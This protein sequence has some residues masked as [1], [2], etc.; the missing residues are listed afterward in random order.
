MYKLNDFTFNVLFHDLVICSREMASREAERPTLEDYI[1]SK[2]EQV[3]LLRLEGGGSPLHP[4]ME[5]IYTDL[6]RRR[7]ESKLRE[8]SRQENFKVS[9]TLTPYE[10]VCL[11][12]E[13][14]VI[15][16]KLKIGKLAMATPTGRHID[17]LWHCKVSSGLVSA[18]AESERKEVAKEM[19]AQSFLRKLE[20]ASSPQLRLANF[21]KYELPK[22]FLI[23]P[24]VIT[25]VEQLANQLGKSLEL[26]QIAETAWPKINSHPVYIAAYVVQDECETLEFKGK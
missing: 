17:H 20:Q 7:E 23:N 3:T 18:M 1:H 12:I 2:M 8:E 24:K 11:L 19:A 5:E 4:E 21:P 16:I 6:L 15:K 10:V 9:V 22:G 25:W 14:D 13:K 26:E